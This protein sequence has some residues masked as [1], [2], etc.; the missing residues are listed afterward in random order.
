MP[1]LDPSYPEMLAEELLD[2]H[3][4]PAPSEPDLAFEIVGVDPGPGEG[5]R[6]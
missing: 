4:I 1:Q 2:E 6:T 5:T 3:G